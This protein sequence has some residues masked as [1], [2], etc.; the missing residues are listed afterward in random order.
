MAEMSIGDAEADQDVHMESCAPGS[1]ENIAGSHTSGWSGEE[2]VDHTLYVHV[3]RE[4]VETRLM[5][6][7]STGACGRCSGTVVAACER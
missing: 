7:S 1:L 2:A 6:A 5:L 3:G 4:L